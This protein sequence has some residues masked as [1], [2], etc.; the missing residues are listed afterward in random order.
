MFLY[1]T[2]DRINSQSGGGQ[3]TYQEHLAL[4]ELGHTTTITIEPNLDPFEQDLKILKEVKNLTT[5]IKL[6]HCYSGCLSQTVQ[7]LKSIGVLVTYTVAAHDKD[8]SRHEHERLGFQ[9]PYPHL[10]Y[11]E[12][13][14]RYI[15][16]YLASTVI[17]APSSYSKRTIEK[18]AGYAETPIEII[19]HGTNLPESISPLPNIFTVGYLGAVG[20]DKGLC[21][22]LEAWK[23]LNYKDAILILAGRDT[24]SPFFQSFVK[25][26]GGGN[27]QLM[28]WVNNIEDFYSK[29]SLYIQPSA[30]EGFGIEILEAMAH[31][32][33][34]ICSEGAGAVDIVGGFLEFGFE[35]RNIKEIVEAISYV[36]SRKDKLKG[37]GE[38][39]RKEAEKY[40][41]DKIRARYQQ[42]WK[43]LLGE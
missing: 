17:V 1:L 10:I 37:M 18:Y 11:P 38:I 22:L 27:I 16:G 24:T 2:A 4:L 30:T 36:K 29:I 28:G 12:L 21:Y 34:V 15:A 5:P 43:K 32:R 26:Y 25:K 40:T 20:P 9:F 35:A 7:Y 6:A 3:V 31:G 41:W 13:W 39:N 23:K 42:L 19:P 8:I 14:K 33:P